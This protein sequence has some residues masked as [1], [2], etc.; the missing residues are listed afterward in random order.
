MAARSLDLLRLV[1]TFV[2]ALSLS[3][4]ISGT[5][6][7]VTIDD[8]DSRVLYQ[9][10][11]LWNGWPYPRCGVAKTI[12]GSQAFRGTWDDVTSGSPEDLKN[13]TLNFTSKVSLT[14]RSLRS[15]HE[16]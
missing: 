12:N 10:A 9:R 3:T 11:E 7:N 6:T 13:L 2:L 1:T 5:S 15:S 8:V 16:S 14:Y 4:L